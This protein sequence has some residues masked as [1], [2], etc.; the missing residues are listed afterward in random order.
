MALPRLRGR[1]VVLPRALEPTWGRQGMVLVENGSKGTWRGSG[2]VLGILRFRGEA[3]DLTL[4]SRGGLSK[5]AVVPQLL[6]EGV[7]TREES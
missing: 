2:L 1:R 3:L 4:G 6:Q 7:L 5:G